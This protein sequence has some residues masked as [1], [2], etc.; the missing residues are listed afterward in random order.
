[1][2]VEVKVRD[3]IAVVISEIIGRGGCHFLARSCG[4]IVL[5]RISLVCDWKRPHSGVRI[6]SHC[7]N[8][9]V[10]HLP[11]FSLIVTFMQNI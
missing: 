8:F 2:L 11:C 1:M 6:I 5:A 9:I 7:H 10:I 3:R 4:D